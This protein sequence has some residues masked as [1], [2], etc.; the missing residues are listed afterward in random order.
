[1]LLNIDNLNKSFEG[2]KVLNDISFNLQKGEVNCF[3]GP[4]GCGKSTLL[5][6]LA[7]LEKADE[8]DL[9][10][11][12]TQSSFIFQDHRLLPWLTAFENVE[13]VLKDKIKD[14]NKRREIV[15]DT[16]ESVNLSSYAN[17]H[18]DKLSGGMKQRVSIAR[19]LAIKPQLIL[20]DEPFSKLDFPLR[21][22]LI[23]LL[24]HIFENENMGGIF[25]TH[26]TREAVLMGDKIMVMAENPGEIKNVIDVDIPK[27][28]RRLG[29]PDIF[30]LN[31]E[32][33]DSIFFHQGKNYG[34]KCCRRRKRIGMKDLKLT[35]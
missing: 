33:N 1:M 25:V 19:A 21:V 26:D 10:I 29:D 27:D 6:I 15:E 5:R 20:M 28:E 14:K 18:P 7:G 30:D 13:L 2:E 12:A 17:F 11:G 32:L 9:K 35:Y 3:L 8:G 24:N 16:L 22:D 4:S 31:Q 34:Q 23:N